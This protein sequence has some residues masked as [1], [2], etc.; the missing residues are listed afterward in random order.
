MQLDVLKMVL[1]MSHI[2]LFN[3]YRTQGTVSWTMGMYAGK[4]LQ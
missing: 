4:K 2:Y 1:L 3:Y